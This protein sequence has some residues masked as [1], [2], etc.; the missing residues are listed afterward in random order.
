MGTGL[1]P[2]G[3]VESPSLDILR[4]RLDALLSSQTWCSEAGSGRPCLDLRVE[5]DD[6]RIP[7]PPQPGYDSSLHPICQKTNSSSVKRGKMV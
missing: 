6:L 4:T 2:R 7:S 3:A 1:L 5:P